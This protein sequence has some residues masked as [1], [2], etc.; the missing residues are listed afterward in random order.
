MKLSKIIMLLGL[1]LLSLPQSAE[2]FIFTRSFSDD[3][4]PVIGRPLD[5]LSIVHW[6]DCFEPDTHKEKKNKQARK[7]HAKKSAYKAS[8]Y[9]RSK[10]KKAQRT[11]RDP[12]IGR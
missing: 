10:P 1:F 8:Q 6:H 4:G 3:L 7:S 11:L 12:R 5:C 9:V 2:A